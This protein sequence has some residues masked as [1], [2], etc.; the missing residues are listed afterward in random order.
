MK[1]IDNVRRGQPLTKFGQS[2]GWGGEV[3]ESLLKF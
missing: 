3:D 1:F 2:A